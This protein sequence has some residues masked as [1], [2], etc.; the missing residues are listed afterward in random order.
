MAKPSLEDLQ[1]RR[2]TATACSVSGKTNL[3]AI[4]DKFQESGLEWSVDHREGN[5]EKLSLCSRISRSKIM[6][7]DITNR[8]DV[9]WLTVD[10]WLRTP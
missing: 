6:R 7:L 8:T 4:L 3:T 2:L 9:S 1:P 10:R 5:H